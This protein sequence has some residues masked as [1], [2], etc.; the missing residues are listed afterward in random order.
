MLL[1]L[2]PAE[3]LS[4]S[5]HERWSAESGFPGGA[6]FAICQS[7]DGYLW[8][9]TERG[10]V[11]FDGRDFTLMQR[12]ISG[13]LPIGAVRGLLA[14]S[15]G[16]LWIRLDGPRL[17]R[18][19]DGAFEDTFSR[20]NLE[21]FAFTSMALDLDRRLLLWGPQNKLMRFH[22]NTFERLDTADEI[23][24]IV[25]S[26]AET[27][28]RQFWMGT[29][30]AGLHEA[31]ET[32]SLS[33][34]SSLALT[35]INALLPSRDGLWI[36]TDSG[37]ALW[38]GHH[39]SKPSSM[40]AL[41]RVQIVTLIRDQRGEI[42]AGTN[43]GL[44][45]IT[46]ALTAPVAPA[47]SSKEES[48]LAVFEDREGSIWFGGPYGLERLRQGMFTGYT[49]AR[50]LP[51]VNDGPIYVDE[52]NRTWFAPSSGGLYWLRDGQVRKVSVS[53]LD[54]DVVYSI[55]GGGGEV[56]VGR[57]HTGLTK[58]TMEDGSFVG[59]TFTEVDGLAQNSIY[60]VHRDSD[61]TVWAATVSQ[62]LSKLSNGHFT[63][64]SIANGLLSN[65]VF[66]ATEASDGTIWFAT[67]GGLQS[68]VDGHFRS[69]GLREGLPS[70]NVRTTFED[71]ERR[72][73][74]GTAAGLAF[75][76]SGQVHVP[77]DLPDSL[78]DE[79][80]GIAED[81]SG[82]LWILT[83]DHVL[84]VSRISL[85]DGSA[86]ETNVQ[87]YGLEDGLP[88]VEGVRRDR[89]LVTDREG[90][91]WVS[92][93]RGLGVADSALA[94]SHA[95]PATVRIEAV[96]GPSGLISRSE[97]HRLPA[98]T[99]S[100]TLRYGASNL[101]S[102]QRV[103]FRYRLDGSET[104]WNPD[105]AM[106]EVVYTNLGPGTYTFRILAS[107]VAGRWDGP[108]TRVN[109]VIQPT[110]WQTW[111]FRTL[112]VAAL[113]AMA[114][115]VLRMRALQ[116]TRRL[117][118][119][120][121]D[122]LA[123]RT[124][125]AQDLHDTL[126]QGVLSASMQLDV[127]EDQT[128]QDSPTKQKIQRILLL[129]EQVTEEGRN[130]LRGLRNPRISNSDIE[131]ALS[132][133][134]HEFSLPGRAAYRVVSYGEH[135]PLC[136]TIRNEVYRIG[137]EAVTNALLHAKAAVVDVDVEYTNAF[138]RLVVRD[139]GCGIEPELLQ[140]GREGHWGLAGMHERSR[141]VGATLRIRSRAAAGTEVELTVPGA[142]A[143]EHRHRTRLSRLS[144]WLGRK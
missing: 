9:G 7:Q 36:G 60:A 5:L 48:V 46:P 85:L 136:P 23:R 26:I 101:D 3:A 12:P 62:G 24:N 15:E 144:A 103:R 139:D 1:F 52:E 56:W 97:L 30:G 102:Y 114:L 29:R 127:V 130:T 66:S 55:N 94:A 6:V 93:R 63:H 80:L 113:L 45:R 32:H 117:N 33:A 123:E 8:I 16:N 58:L 107:D 19:R 129:M 53:G 4:Q 27:D 25:V 86:R 126:L 31:G 76:S 131:A 51:P 70:L 77:R 13:S 119:R 57:Q 138:F 132:Q 17:L 140:T 122:R 14:D 115:L 84:Q 41:N 40:R 21:E 110:V 49:S 73:W 142:A 59:Q 88:G 121:Q 104:S 96:L 105:V 69:Y 106:R 61:G 125:I 120:F 82:S 116:I 100:L 89:S 118:A 109:F 67:S 72:L 99:H 75:F 91:I 87:K 143:Y 92:L 78:R 50:G 44:F 112:S 111:W 34:L 47:V 83:T 90:R 18:Y 71:S 95:I 20:F 141:A 22:R 35:S 135:R 2:G 10:L 38:D 37:I 74:V 64:Y 42:W 11:R 108:E 43:R 133:L 81:R 54:H 68:F 39:L 28:D 128:P 98:G 79:V 124:M 65:S 137:R 134:D